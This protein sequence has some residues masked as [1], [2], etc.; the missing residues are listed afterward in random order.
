V[1][2]FG[3]EERRAR[4]GI[5]HHLAASAKS[6]DVAAVAGAL[7]GFHGTD[8]ASVFLAA[9]A[10]MKKPQIESIERA[11]YDDRTIVRM[12]AMR[13][14]MFVVPV[15]LV[16]MV[17]AAASNA[18]A[19]KERKALIQIIE[20]AGIATNGD[21]WL[22]KADAAT[23][24]ALDQRGEATAAELAK[25]VPELR[26]QFQFG[27]GKKWEATVSIGTRALFLLS[28]EGHIVRGRP[29]GSWISTQH[30]WVPRDR[31][32]PGGV[33]EVSVDDA[34]AELVTRW[35]RSFGP[36]TVADVK[37][38]T[39]WTMGETR[40][41]LGH[42][43]VVEV[44]LDGTTGVALADDLERTKPPKPC[45]ALLPALDPTAMGWTA[46]D[47][48]LGERR[49]ALF[50]RSGNAGP[51]IWWNG[52]VVGGWAQRADGEIATRLLEDVG[53]DATA[54]VTAE[55]ERLAT[56]LGDRRFTS[57][58]PTPLERDLRS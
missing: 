8:P 5:R 19:A 26:E 29:R 16:G 4:L 56:W 9:A 36:A 20:S 42:V 52:R 2:H 30:R 33:D 58:F 55:A 13:R 54:A 41:A 31:W 18:I 3:V 11:L 47:W 21:S 25:D 6:A 51:T 38:W 7:I 12:L 28:A 46:R 43:D 45:A 53:K 34:R 37:W 57:R 32:L 24:A 27:A 10:R 17:Q 14:T 44:D 22:R 48:Y 40:K 1:Q 50:D 35:L 49:H 39:G 23:L 15:E